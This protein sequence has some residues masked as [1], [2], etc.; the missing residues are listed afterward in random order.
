MLMYA[1]NL[2]VIELVNLR[3]D[4]ILIDRM[5]LFVKGEKGKKDRYTV[6]SK[7]L[8]GQRTRYAKDYNPAYWLFEGQ[9]YGQ[10]SVRN[11]QAILR[12]AVTQS[13]VNPFATVHTLCHSF[14]THLQI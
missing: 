12:Q 7:K 14:A 9:E 4:D 5:Q 10:Y 11:V 13:G 8:L 6:F 1:N 3:K 2:I